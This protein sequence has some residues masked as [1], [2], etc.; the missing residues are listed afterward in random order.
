MG[1][2]YSEINQDKM[3]QISE[4][5]LALLSSMKGTEDEEEFET[6]GKEKVLAFIHGKIEEEQKRRASFGKAWDFSGEKAISVFAEEDDISLVP[7]KEADREYYLSVRKEY[8]DICHEE[9]TGDW[10]KT[11]REESFY[12]LILLAGEPCGYLGIKD[13]SKNLWELAVELDKAHCYR[14]FGGK[15]VMI[16]LEKISEITGKTQFQALVESDNQ[17][18]QKC[19]EK[20]GA[21]LIDIFLEAFSDEEEAAAFE[22]KHLDMITPSMCELAER[23]EVEPQKLLS[24]VLDYRIILTEGSKH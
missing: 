6:R 4:E 21:R 12:C 10:T 17:A 16:F 14:G 18:S 22:E 8:W 1:K 20:M 23:L 2:I 7:M 9:E 5:I 24:H 3:D 19:F 15:A 11:Q 13:T